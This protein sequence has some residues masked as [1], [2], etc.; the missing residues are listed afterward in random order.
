MTQNKNQVILATTL[1][2]VAIVSRLLFNAVH[3]YG[4]DAVIAAGFFAGAYFSS[5]KI[6]I[7][8]PLL[9]MFA[10]D[11][12]LGIYD[13]KLMLFV[14]GSMVLAVA[15]GQFYRIRPSLLRWT[16]VVLGS[17]TMFFLVTNGAVWLFGEGTFYPHSW[18]GLVDCYTM[19][20]PFFRDRLIGTFGWSAVLFASYEALR[21]RLPQAAGA[22]N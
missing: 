22:Q 3:I 20:L 6:G 19:G 17:T 12:F 10:T 21:Y 14:D 11:L 18:A 15:L 2:I 4:F 7:I 5:K 9:A 8:V 13:W 16:G 1:V